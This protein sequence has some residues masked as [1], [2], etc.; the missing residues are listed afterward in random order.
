MSLPISPHLSLSQALKGFFLLARGEF[1]QTFYDESRMM[2]QLPPTASAE[3]DINSGPLRQAGLKTGLEDDS[4]FDRFKF[5]LD[6]R[7]RV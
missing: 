7:E 1:F 3:R 4:F 2:M 6:V 5:H